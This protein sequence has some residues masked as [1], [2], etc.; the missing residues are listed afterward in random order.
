MFSAVR[1]MSWDTD[2]PRPTV[3]PIQETVRDDRHSAKLSNMAP[4]MPL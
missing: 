2:V 3:D 4:S 1:N